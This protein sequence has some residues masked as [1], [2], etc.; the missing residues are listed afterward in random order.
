MLANNLTSFGVLQNKEEGKMGKVQDRIIE[1]PDTIRL[2]ILS[3]LPRKSAIRTSV[4]STQ[5]KDLWRYRWPY[6]TFL[7]FGAEFAEGITSEEFVSNVNQ[8]LQLRSDMKVEI[9]RLFFDPG[10]RY[11]FDVVRWIEYAGPGACVRFY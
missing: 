4:L 2:H 7:D 3:L 6:P 5:W 10:T 8:I 1:L 11:Q 9:F